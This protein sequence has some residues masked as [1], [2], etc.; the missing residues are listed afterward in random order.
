M[1]TIAGFAVLPVTCGPKD[2]PVLHSLYIRR[3]E[4]HGSHPTLPAGRTLFIVNLPTDATRSTIRDLFRK[5]GAVESIDFHNLADY[6]ARDA[7]EYEDEE[8][9][10][11]APDQPTKKKGPPKVHALP[12]LE[13]NGMPFLGSASNAHL[14]F[15]DESSLDR[16]M[17]LPNKLSKPLRWPQPVSAS[18]A[19]RQA[20][21]DPKKRK[22]I[23]LMGLD[24]FVARHRTRRPPLADV[25]KHAD[26]SIERFAWIR[27]HPQWLL[28]QRKQGDTTTGVGIGIQGTSIGPNGELL[29]Q[30]GFI[31]V[32]RGGRYGRSG[33]GEE[34][35]YGSMAA[36]TPEFEAYMKENPDAKKPKELQDFYRFQFRE[37]K[38]QQFAN[39]RAQFE[40][41]KERVARLKATR[42]FKPY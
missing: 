32:Q 19:A 16:A 29:D 42:R 41:D 4:P 33:G 30:D 21:E 14:V 18:E 23:H 6:S 10:V 15:V 25:K 40:A 11:G 12:S 36:A 3:H 5:A 31:I 8:L 38:R 20:D 39:L 9:D 17:E 27:E 13:P 37:K 7:E 2:A 35:T 22:K 34:N 26:T 1:R 24:Y 28:D